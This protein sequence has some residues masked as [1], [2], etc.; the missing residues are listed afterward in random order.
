MTTIC[1]FRC[2]L[3]PLIFAGPGRGPTSQGRHEDRRPGPKRPVGPGGR[4]FKSCLPDSVVVV[5]RRGRG[6]AQG[7]GLALGSGFRVGR[8]AECSLRA[9][10]RFRATLP[11]KP[12]TLSRVGG[13]D[14][15]LPW[16]P[17]LEAP[18]RCPRLGRSI[19]QRRRG[20][21]ACLRWPW[22]G[23]GEQRLGAR[24]SLIVPRPAGGGIRRLVG[25]SLR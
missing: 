21:F 9:A 17:G 24:C 3:A 5:C 8:G 22:P 20:V 25:G 2:L 16:W 4:R 6:R 11:T 23:G 13:A 10:T 15:S 19:F 12:P 14:A 1:A 18:L 7:A